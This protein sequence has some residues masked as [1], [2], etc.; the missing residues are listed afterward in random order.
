MNILMMGPQGSGKGTVGKAISEK[1]GIPL[2]STGDMFREAMANQTPMGIEAKKYVD[3]GILV[4]DDVTIK[5]V[6]ERISQ[7]DCEKGFILD[8][9]PR[10]KAQAQAL[11]NITNI[12]MIISL[13]VSEEEAIERLV[14][15]RTC[16]KCSAIYNTRSYSKDDCE[17]C[18][19]PL[20]V[21]QDDSDIE[22]IKKRFATF[23]EQ[24]LPLI[25]Y[26]KQKTT[27]KEIDVTEGT[28]QDNREKV[29]KETGL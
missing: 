17:K 8:G 26:Y 19:A 21:R 25:A 29:F 12:D 1:H 5:L 22:A 10:N 16:S 20:K 27:V 28:I 6:K 11:D 15:R 23:K 24:T 3:N 7:Q 18:G 4:P 13:E 2:I 14:T 9:Y